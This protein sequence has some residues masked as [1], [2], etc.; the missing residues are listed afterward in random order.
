MGPSVKTFYSSCMLGMLGIAGH[1]A[2]AAAVRPG[3]GGPATDPKVHMLCFKGSS[4]QFQ[5]LPWETKKSA[6]GSLLATFQRSFS[7]FFGQQKIN[8]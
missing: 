7:R 6:T 2:A 8:R 4:Q 1:H 5:D 3:N